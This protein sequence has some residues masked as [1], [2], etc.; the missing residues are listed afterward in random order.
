[1]YTDD[2]E[3]TEKTILNTMEL[4]VNEFIKTYDLDEYIINRYTG[5][6]R[7]FLKCMFIKKK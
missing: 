7:D 2:L 6:Y 1:M 3:P 4:E 5:Y